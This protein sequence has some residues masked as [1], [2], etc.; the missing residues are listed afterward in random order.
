MA[1][2]SP[3]FSTRTCRPKARSASTRSRKVSF[4]H[5]CCGN[6]DYDDNDDGDDD[7]AEIGCCCC[8]VCTSSSACGFGICIGIWLAL[9]K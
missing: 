2:S 1:S 8:S 5:S 9:L 7:E 3:K 4:S 6:A